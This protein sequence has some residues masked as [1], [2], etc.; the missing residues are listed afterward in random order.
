MCRGFLASTLVVLCAGAAFGAPASPR[1]ARGRPFA[2]FLADDASPATR[3]SAAAGI[4]ALGGRVFHAFDDVLVVELPPGGELRASRLPGVLELTPN[5]AATAPRRRGSGP[6]FGRAAWSAIARDPSTVDRGNDV[7]GPIEDDALTPREVSLDAVRAA[8]RAAFGATGGS[9]G[10]LSAGSFTTMSAPFGATPLNT[11]EFLAGAVSVNIVLVESDGSNE[12]QSENWSATRENEVVSGIAAG[13]EWI[14]LQ[15][16]QASL[17]FVYHVIPGRTDVRGRTG[18]EPIRHAADPSGITGEDRWATEVLGKIGYTGGDRFA[19]SRAFAADTRSADGT[20]WAVNIFVVDSLADTDGKFADGRFAYCYI[21]GPHLVMTYDNQAWGI[22]RMD[23][24]LRHELLHAFYA[25]DE[26][27]TSSCDCT[28]HR[29]YLDGANVNCAACNAAASACV[30]IA[31]GDAMCD[32]TRRHL[33]WADLDGDGVIDVLGQDPDTFLDAIPANVCSAPVL[34]GLASVVA[35]TNRNTFPGTTH[36][37][38]S[39]NRISGVEFRVDGSPWI[40]AQ[41]AGGTW[42]IAQ[43]RFSAASPVLP[44]GSH[45]LEARA[46]DDVGNRDGAPGTAD[47]VVHVAVAPLGASLRAARTGASGLAISWGACEGAT[48]YRV[49]RRAG[50]SA[51]ESLVAETSGTAWTDAGATSGY[52]QVRPVDACGGERSD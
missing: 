1:A 13:L 40:L 10:A 11:S 7:P 12:P 31:N 34:T 36:P 8:S 49:Y 42:G 37:S 17:R 44:P 48:L 46:V 5:G 29:G 35:A 21:G 2:V 50:P 38:I 30:M 41:P 51:T 43:E 16:P 15:E 9:R 24:V 4:V 26:Y 3:R 27:A 22:A 6:W 52:Y 33:G 18:Y 45:H 20:D 14:R 28:S 32:A 25:F 23:M 39:V 19:R 47:V